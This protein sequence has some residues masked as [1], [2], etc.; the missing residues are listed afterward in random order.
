MGTDEVGLVATCINRLTPSTTMSLPALSLFLAT[1]LLVGVTVMAAPREVV[2]TSW[3]VTLGLLG[4]QLWKHPDTASMVPIYLLLVVLGV[5]TLGASVRRRTRGRTR[6]R[7]RPRLLLALASLPLLAIPVIEAV[8]IPFDAENYR[9]KGWVEAF[10]ALHATLKERYAFGDW[11]RVDW[12]RLHERHRDDIMQ[13]ER[14]GDEAYF[15]LSLRDYLYG[16]PDGHVSIRWHHHDELE[17][18]AIGGGFG[19][20]LLTLNDGTVIAHIVEEGG[21]A[22][23]AGIRWGAEVLEWDAQPIEQAIASVST[24]WASRPVAT[25]YNRALAQQQLL[26]RATEGEDVEITFRNHDED[27]QRTTSLIARDDDRGLYWRSVF[28]DVRQPP[29]EP[30]SYELVSPGVGYIRV[31]SLESSSTGLTP[32]EAMDVAMRTLVDRGMRALIVDVR[33]N[34]GGMDHFVPEMM[35]YFASDPVFYEGVTT[36][37]K[38]LGQFTQF[39]TLEVEPN[40]LQF[41]GPVLVLIDHRTKSSGEGF[42]LLAQSLPTVSSMGFHPTDGSFG[43]AEA[44]VHMPAGITAAFPW[45]QSVDQNGMVQVEGNHALEGGVAPDVKVPVTFE[46]ARAM[47]VDGTDVLLDEAV[48]QLRQR[49]DE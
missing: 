3:L 22:A 11:K 29:E 39:L 33:G 12:E 20:A 30:L 18:A 23:E 21:P 35:G 14:A 28:A 26:P 45:G 10:D 42:A 15:Y 32:P 5:A 16:L 9:D 41:Q 48:E 8:A 13:A 43:M 37:N 49:L 1:T 40:E 44:T 6:S 47:Y 17:Q 25:G 27:A 2:G 31:A 46:R 4:W 34:R 38:L 19:I 24:R 7:R 36:Y